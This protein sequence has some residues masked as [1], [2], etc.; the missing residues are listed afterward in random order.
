MALAAT[1]VSLDRGPTLHP[2]TA[3]LGRHLKLTHLEIS[4]VWV[5]KVY[6]FGIASAQR[7]KGNDPETEAFQV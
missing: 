7:A 6:A 4:E 1:F 3:I 5:L 2:K